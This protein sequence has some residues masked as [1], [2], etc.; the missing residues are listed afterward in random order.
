MTPPNQLTKAVKGLI[1][2]LFIPVFF[3]LN[4]Y[5]EEISLKYEFEQPVLESVVIDGQTYDRIIIPGAPNAGQPGEPALPASGA[6]IL[7]PYGTDIDNIEVIRENKVLIGKGFYIEPNG[8]PFPLSATADQIKAPTP[9]TAIYNSSR[10]FPDYDHK[11]LG[12]QFFRGYQVLTLKLIPVEYIPATGELSYYR[13][14]QV[15]VNT[16]ANSRENRLFRGFQSDEAQLL[17]K[18]DNPAAVTSYQAAPKRGSRSYDLLIITNA[19]LAGVFDMLKTHHDAAGIATQISTVEDIGSNLP[20]DI[21]AFITDK[22]ITE[23]IEYVLI[24]GDDDLIPAIDLYVESWEGEDNYIDYDMPGDIYF[25]C[26][27]GTYNYDGDEYNGEIG[28][29]EGGGEIDLIAEVYVGRAAVGTGSEAFAFVTKT[30]TYFDSSDPYLNNVVMAG[31]QLTFSGLGE[32]GGY[33]L[34]EIIDVSH[35]HGYTT[36]GIPADQYNLDKLYDMT[37]PGNHWPQSEIIS[38]INN[39][40]GVINHYGHCNT[41]WALKMT[42]DNVMNYLTNYDYCFIYSQGC[43]AGNFDGA[44]CWAEYVTVKSDRGAY[45]AVMNSRY[46][47]GDWDTDGPSQRFDREFFDAVYNPDENMQQFGKANQDSKEDNLYRIDESCMRWCYYQLIL[48]GDPTLTF[49]DVRGMVFEYPNDVPRAV[50][51]EQATTIDVTVHGIGE[52]APVAGSGQ[53]H[54]SING[55]E[56]QTAAMTPTKADGYTATLPA[57][58]CDDQIAF[59]F[60]AEEAVDGR[61]YDPAPESAFT[62]I[63]TIETEFL[64]EDDFETDKGWAVSGGLW[65]RGIPTG[66]GGGDQQ[67]GI[68]D[69]TQGC[70]GDNL[71]GYNLNGDYQNGTPAYH[72]TSPEINCGGVDNVY[73]SFCRWLGVEMPSHDYACISVSTNDTDWTEIWAN[74]CTIND[75]LWMNIDLDLTTYAAGEDNVKIRFT[76]G[77]TDGSTRYCGWNIDDV[78]VYTYDCTIW[79]CGDF[80]GDE[81]VNIIDIS[82]LISYLYLDGPPPQALDAV[83]VNNDGTV[84]IL[85]I[86]YLIAYLYMGGPAPNCP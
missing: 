82:S 39:G 7:I 63:V 13:N 45:A 72:V 54:Y 25:G 53:V 17:K 77:P 19:A 12:A 10:A 15:I 35:A 42:S 64:F 9:N 60:S 33:S 46:G 37:F 86:S 62:A 21:R 85:D 58:V 56:F 1:I 28:D 57:L 61:V 50:I 44:E 14:I 8:F 47:F 32:Y 40:V 79:I 43:Y 66:Q 5:S 27:D 81:Q 3:G 2:S 68:P 59:Y 30:M 36:Y 84:N 29:G 55:G 71:I 31:E 69:P 52:G 76:M 65:A 48:F 24:G 73:L 26:L 83:D 67:Y 80:G 16:S 34:D 23:G 41:S 70:N 22:Y 20:D 18:I 6:R 11:N 74:G 75:N 4:V 51:N 78:K 38:R 49:R